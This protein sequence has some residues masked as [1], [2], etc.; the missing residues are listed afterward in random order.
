MRGLSSPYNGFWRK[1]CKIQHVG[2]S[3]R[4]SL[5]YREHQTL[6]A[7]VLLRDMYRDVAGYQTD[8]QRFAASVVLCI[9]YGRR[10]ASMQDEAVVFNVNAINEFQRAPGKYLVDAWPL[11]LWLPRPLQWFRHE[12]DR[13]RTEDSKFYLSLVQEVRQRMDAGKAKESMTSRALQSGYEGLSDIELAY[14]LAAPFGAGVDT[15]FA[16]ML[17]YS[18]TQKAQAELDR[19]VG[20]DRLPTFEDMVTLPYV[21]AYIKELER[22]RPVVPLAVPHSVIRD[23]DFEGYQIPKGT[24]VYAN[25][26]T[27]AQDSK[28]FPDPDEFR[29]ERFLPRDDGTLDARFRDFTLPFGFGRRQCPGMHVASQSI[30]IFVTR[31]LWAFDVVAEPGSPP[32][33]SK[34]YINHGLVRG[35]ASFRF[36]LRP[37]SPESLKVLE[38]EAVEADI[39]LK[40][41]D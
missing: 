13:K 32:P 11:L 4:A 29:P 39:R 30:Y 31:L 23:D 33:D 2:M 17:F 3:G 16:A 40:E 24:T 7:T 15:V 12:A 28:M 5:A 6:E 36:A 25:I 38:L 21:G 34:A 20:R 14:V 41:W 9:S 19:V 18:K 22:W 26:Y 37:R 1:W 27:M 35:P 8:V 10:A